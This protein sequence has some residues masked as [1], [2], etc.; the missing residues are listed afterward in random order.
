MQSIEQILPGKMSCRQFQNFWAPLYKCTR[1]Y[2]RA[3]EAFKGPKTPHFPFLGHPVLH[4]KIL[5]DMYKCKFTIHEIFK[6]DGK[7]NLRE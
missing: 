4:Q 1:Y 5:L 3:Q 7:N 6:N 2:G